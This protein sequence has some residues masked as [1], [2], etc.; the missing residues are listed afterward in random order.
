MLAKREAENY[1]PRTLLVERP[2]SG[3]DHA[4]MI[5]VWDRLNDLQKDF[6]DMNNG[7][8][9]VLSDTEQQL[10][11]GISQADR[12]LLVS[13]FGQ[14]VYTCWNVWGVQIKSELSTRGQGDLEQGIALIRK[15]V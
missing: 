2:D 14:N 7:L 13:G 12:A 4:Q 10:F 3:A 1:L 15:E 11:E 6:Y 8:P 9:E 5:E